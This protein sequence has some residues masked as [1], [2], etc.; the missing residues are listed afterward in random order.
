MMTRLKYFAIPSASNFVE[1]K[2]KGGG[3]I[4]FVFTLKLGFESNRQLLSPSVD[5]SGERMRDR[6]REGKRWYELRG[7]FLKI[8]IF[9]TLPVQKLAIEYKYEFIPGAGDCGSIPT[10]TSD[11]LS[12]NTAPTYQSRT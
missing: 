9:K 5:W 4:E 12:R 2:K 7:P 1:F 11:P 8:N 6:N 3:G 10:G